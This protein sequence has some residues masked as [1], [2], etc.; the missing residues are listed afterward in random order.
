MSSRHIL[1]QECVEA[2]DEASMAICLLDPAAGF[3]IGGECLGID[4]LG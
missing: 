1:S 3:G 4:P 2:G